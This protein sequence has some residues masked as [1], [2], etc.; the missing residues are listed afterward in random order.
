MRETYP[1][2]TGP[3]HYLALLVGISSLL[4]LPEV[5]RQAILNTGVVA[6]IAFAGFPLGTLAN[7]VY[8]AAWL[9]WAGYYR[10]GHSRIATKLFAHSLSPHQVS[11]VHDAILWQHTSIEQREYFQRRWGHCHLNLLLG[12]ATYLAIWFPIALKAVRGGWLD[13][14]WGSGRKVLILI[15]YELVLILLTAFLVRILEPLFDSC[16]LRQ[17]FTPRRSPG[18][19]GPFQIEG[20]LVAIDLKRDS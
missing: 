14:A 16:R 19:S 5:D 2:F 6:G 4:F 8:S 1:L 12:S 13:F 10:V 17:V 18:L 15:A 20:I 3:G 11:A 9:R 7:A